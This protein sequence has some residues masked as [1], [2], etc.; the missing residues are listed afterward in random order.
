MY[1][2]RPLKICGKARLFPPPREKQTSFFPGLSLSTVF[3]FASTILAF[4]P[5]K[6]T[7]PAVQALLFSLHR[8]KP[9]STHCPT[10]TDLKA[11]LPYLFPPPTLLPGHQSLPGTL[12]R[13]YPSAGKR[14]KA[15][16]TAPCRAGPS[17]FPQRTLNPFLSYSGQ[18]AG[19][20]NTTPSCLRHEPS[21][22]HS[23]RRLFL[24]CIVRPFIEELMDSQFSEEILLWG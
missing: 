8:S 22:H 13:S 23:A 14:H 11:A 24:C 18:Q 3:S 2:I 7:G 1:R 9:R 17:S 21:R 12:R 10:A 19:H 4:T 6:A 15:R 16:A 5:C 20:T